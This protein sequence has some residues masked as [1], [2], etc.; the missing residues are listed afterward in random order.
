M[1]SDVDIQWARPISG[2]NVKAKTRVKPSAFDTPDPAVGGASTPISLPLSCPSS[3]PSTAPS[4]AAAQLAVR[5]AETYLLLPERLVASMQPSRVRLRRRCCCRYWH[6]QRQRAAAPPRPIAAFVVKTS[7]PPA[8]SLAT[9]STPTNSSTATASTF[10]RP[11][12]SVDARWH[13]RCLTAIGSHSPYSPGRK[14]A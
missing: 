3:S 5:P 9:S 12:A 2:R 13:R 10:R 11:A 1:E 8:A 6:R 4:T 7:T 14:P